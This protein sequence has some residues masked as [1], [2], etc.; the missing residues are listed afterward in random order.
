MRGAKH[1]YNAS[2]GFIRVPVL[3]SA[4]IDEIFPSIT[5]VHAQCCHTTEAQAIADGLVGESGFRASKSYSERRTAC[6]KVE[7]QSV[8]RY[9]RYRSA[10]NAAVSEE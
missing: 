9:E 2:I 1:Q 3:R 7:E 10:Y 4:Y 6:S 8:R 5:A